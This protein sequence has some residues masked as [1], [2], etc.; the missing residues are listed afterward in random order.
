[1]HSE[2][3]YASA[4]WSIECPVSGQGRGGGC[5][6]PVRLHAHPKATPR[7]NSQTGPECLPVALRCPLLACSGP[8][9]WVV[10]RKARRGRRGLRGTPGESSPGNPFPSYWENQESDPPFSTGTNPLEPLG[11]SGR[12]SPLISQAPNKMKTSILILAAT[13]CH[14]SLLSAECRLP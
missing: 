4:E 1:M 7:K 6:P 11:A 8:R 14:L 3:A 13:F 5:G 9:A 2:N 12:I 10:P